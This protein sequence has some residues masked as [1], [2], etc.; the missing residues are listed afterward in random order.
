MTTRRPSLTVVAIAFPF[1]VSAQQITT[2]G[3]PARLSVRAAAER[4]LRVTLA[5]IG[6]KRDLPF[7]PAIADRR[8]PDAAI[9]LTTLTRP[10]RRRVGQLDVEVR[11]NPLTVTVTA[12]DGKPVQQLT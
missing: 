11:A 1:A 6:Y 8:Y 12:P 10:V 3:Q 5:P 4:T 7:S 9:S 2:L